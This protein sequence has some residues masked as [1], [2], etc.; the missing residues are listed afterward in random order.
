[1]GFA[2]IANPPGLGLLLT[3]DQLVLVKGQLF[4]EEDLV[5]Q[6]MIPMTHVTEA[7]IVGEDSLQIDAKDQQST[8]LLLASARFKHNSWADE[9]EGRWKKKKLTMLQET[10]TRWAN[11]ALQKQRSAPGTSG[12]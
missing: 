8:V 2:R 6:R 1:M 4:E 5:I 12:P 3:I 7:K 9:D 10:I 11:K